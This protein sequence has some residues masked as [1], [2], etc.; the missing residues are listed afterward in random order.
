MNAELMTAY[1]EFVADRLLRALDCQA[2]YRTKNPFEWMENI[3]LGGKANFFEHKVSSYQKA[4]VL[5][6]W[7]DKCQEAEQQQQQQQQPSGKVSGDA[8]PYVFRT[9]VDF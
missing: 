7:L 1:I 2:L 9:D 5:N 4:N 8:D 6:A 3:S